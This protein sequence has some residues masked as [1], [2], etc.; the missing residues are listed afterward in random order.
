MIDNTI[1]PSILS[2][3]YIIRLLIASILGAIIGIERDIHGRAAGLRTNLLVSLGSA[4]FMLVSE[5]I[6]LSFETNISDSLIRTDPGRIAAQIITGIGFLGAGTI[7]KYGFTVKGLTTAACLWLSASIGMSA[8]AGLIEL[9]LIVTII[10]LF[11][12]VIF[13]LLEKIYAKDSY[14]ILEITT[15]NNANIS[16]I[17]N[18]MATKNLKITR[19]D[20]ERNYQE[21]KMVLTFN[22]KI[23]HKGITDKLSYKIVTNIEKIGIPIHKIKWYHL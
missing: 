20:Q 1:L 23:F 19:L 2:D 22:I 18:A 21:D 17:I 4:V 7:I 6:A 14:R 15:S 11:S 16:E 9:A 5:H 13:N 8:G 12:L 10:G 3:N